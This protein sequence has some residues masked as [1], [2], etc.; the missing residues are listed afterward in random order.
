PPALTAAQMKA[1]DDQ[2]HFTSSGNAEILETWLERAI[3]NHYQTAYPAVERFLTSV[4]RRK[5]LKPL[6]TKLAATPEG[7]KMAKRIYAKARPTYHPLSQ[8]TIDRIV[9]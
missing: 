3:E 9:K 2:F 8:A 4:G 6:Y 5:Y 7:L 1:L